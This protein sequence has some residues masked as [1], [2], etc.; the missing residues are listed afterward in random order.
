MT[1]SHRCRGAAVKGTDK[2][3]CTFPERLGQRE[4]L[5]HWCSSSMLGLLALQVEALIQSRLVTLRG[6]LAI[7]LWERDR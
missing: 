5:H 2:D 4:H 1:A 7:S 3:R 6:G